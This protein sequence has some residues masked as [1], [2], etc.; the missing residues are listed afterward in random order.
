MKKQ[1]LFQYAILWH[2][3]EKQ[4]KDSGSKTLILV[5]PTV[6]LGADQNSVAMGAAM[7][8]PV[9]YKEQLDQIEIAI[10]PF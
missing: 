2:P 9:E 10:R 6:V 4:F 5:Q 7:K 8:I 3:T 1:T